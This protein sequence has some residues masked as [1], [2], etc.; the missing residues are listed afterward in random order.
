MK[1]F[2]HIEFVLPND[3]GL[4]KLVSRRKGETRIG[5]VVSWRTKSGYT[6]ENKRFHIL[7]IEE[8]AGPKANGGF[9]GS[10]NAFKTFIPKFFGVQS[11]RFL[12]GDNIMIHGVLRLKGYTDDLQSIV[13]E[14]DDFVSEWTADV[15]KNNGI[16]IVIGGGHNNAYGLIK[17][18][19]I[20]LNQSV[21]VVN[22]DPHADTRNL[23]GRHSGNPFSYAWSEGYLK[24]YRV[25]GL[26]Q[27]YNN[28]AIYQR[29][30]EMKSVFTFFDDW[31]M[32]SQK[33]SADIKN[34]IEDFS[35]VNYGVELD[36]DSIAFMPSSAF[37]PSGITL[38]QARF[39]IKSVGAGKNV[40]YLHLPEAAPLT[41]HEELITGKAL[42][43]LVTDFIKSAQ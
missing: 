31:I 20:A 36:M 40:R 26:H 41:E 24:H 9:G 30:S 17:G 1:Q 3:A 6:N 18:L 34:T 35:E 2:E 43:Y 37:T 16:P 12:T 27:S 33:F 25:L 28:E 14:L 39:Y 42:T 11:N 23:E 38:E 7:G 4:Q 15:V 32:D 19:S 10:A 13:T 5:E 22:L 29:L 21:N 8:D